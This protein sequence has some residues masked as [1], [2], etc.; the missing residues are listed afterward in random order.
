MNPAIAAFGLSIEAYGGRRD[1]FDDFSE[2]WDGGGRIGIF[3]PVAQFSL[4]ADYNLKDK[5]T[6]FFVS[7]IH[8]FRRG[9]FLVDG[10]SLRIDYLPDEGI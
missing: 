5:E 1:Q 9:G 7:L 6:D 4:G 8:P 3:S 2:G 10:G